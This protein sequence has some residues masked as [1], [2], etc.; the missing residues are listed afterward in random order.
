M[1][2]CSLS[3]ASFPLC[4]CPDTLLFRQA[5]LSPYKTPFSSLFT[6]THPPPS[7]S[8]PPVKISTFHPPHLGISPEG[9]LSSF[10]ISPCSLAALSHS[11][12][13]YSLYH[14]GAYSKR[15]DASAPDSHSPVICQHCQLR[16]K[17]TSLPTYHPLVP[18]FCQI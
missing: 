13:S 7:P 11:H 15:K 18:L 17:D 3:S 1:K 8:S 16:W 14:L 6:I 12:L 9:R 10:P 4:L 5:L 2:S